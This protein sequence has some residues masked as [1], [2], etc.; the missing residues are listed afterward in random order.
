MKLFTAVTT[1]HLNSD[2]HFWVT[3]TGTNKRSTVL[4][5]LPFLPFLAFS[6]PHQ[7]SAEMTALIFALSGF[8]D[9]PMGSASPSTRNPSPSEILWAQIDS[10]LTKRELTGPLC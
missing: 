4:V 1:I 6:W 9:Q 10:Y 5:F 8:P 2:D 3:Y 7:E